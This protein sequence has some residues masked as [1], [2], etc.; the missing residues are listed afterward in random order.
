MIY[1][2]HIT[3][4]PYFETLYGYVLNG[5]RK[6]N[7]TAEN[8]QQIGSTIALITDRSIPLL[9]TKTE[10]L[11]RHIR[12]RVVILDRTKRENTGQ[13]MRYQILMVQK[14]KC[15]FSFSEINGIWHAY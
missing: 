15:F 1:G 4:L 14:E 11:A 9:I 8:D 10:A 12:A 2:I 3:K 7:M 13:E 5:N 6:K